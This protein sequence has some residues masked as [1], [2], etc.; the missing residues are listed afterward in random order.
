MKNPPI[1]QVHKKIAEIISE[2]ESTPKTRAFAKLQ[3]WCYEQEEKGND[4]FPVDMVEKAKSVARWNNKTAI[5]GLG[6]PM[7]LLDMIFTVY[8]SI[9]H[10]VHETER[11]AWQKWKQGIDHDAEFRTLS[12]EYF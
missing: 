8:E 10:E 1:E 9:G 12:Y 2:E 7:Q 11:E 6:S 5:N 3:S 4:L